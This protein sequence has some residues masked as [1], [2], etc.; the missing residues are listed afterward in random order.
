MY[1]DDFYVGKLVSIS[2]LVYIV[3]NKPK[4]LY[5]NAVYGEN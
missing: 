2:L 1:T 5:A 4:D 3:F